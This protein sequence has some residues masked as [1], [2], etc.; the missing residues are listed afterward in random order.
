MVI[1]HYV[2]R[3]FETVLVHRFSNDTMPFM[4]I[5]K[6]STHYWIFFGLFNMYFFLHPDY[7]A[8]EWA[9]DKIFIGFTILFCIFEFLNLQCHLVLKNLRK[10]GTTERGIPRGWGFEYVSCANYLWEA[11]AWLT[12][13]V[14]SQVLGAYFFLAVSFF[15]MLQWALQ[16]HNRYQKDFGAKYPKGRKAMV[17]FII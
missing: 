13:A 17:P 9:S 12:F 2:K 7:T 11:L 1:L 3:E 14:Q 4:N 10:P 5:F 8:P 15:Q 16:K 6:N